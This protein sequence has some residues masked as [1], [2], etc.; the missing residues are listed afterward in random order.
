MWVYHDFFVTGSGSGP[1]LRI[2]PD[3]DPK[4]PF[5][6]LYFFPEKWILIRRGCAPQVKMII[7]ILHLSLF[8]KLTQHVKCLL[9]SRL[10]STSITFI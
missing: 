6:E 7:I 1:M 9:R 3:P 8:S 2:Q 4:H 10:L 5:L